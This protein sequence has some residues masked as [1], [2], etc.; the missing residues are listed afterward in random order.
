[1][2]SWLS[3]IDNGFPMADSHS[4]LMADSHSI[5]R[6]PPIAAWTTC[7]ALWAISAQPNRNLSPGLPAEAGVSA[8][9][10]STHQ[11][12]Q[13]SGWRVWWC[14]MDHLCPPLPTLSGSK[15]TPIPSFGA[16]SR[17]LTAAPYLSQQTSQL[18]KEVTLVR[19]TFLFHSSLPGVLV[20]SRFFF[21]FHPTWIS[22]DLS[23]S[24]DCIRYLLSAFSGYPV[25]IVPHVDVFLICLLRGSEL[26]ALLLHHFVPPPLFFS[27]VWCVIWSKLVDKWFRIILLENNTHTLN[28]VLMHLSV[29]VLLI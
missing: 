5:L 19:E 26:H 22:R 20:P 24:F 16:N 11:Q 14:G 1:M 3:H 28:V 6:G 10:C 17:W 23:Y 2:A 13:V 12:E 9:N 4:I 15:P 25:R 8:P 27:N 21:S 18:A 7:Q 29:F